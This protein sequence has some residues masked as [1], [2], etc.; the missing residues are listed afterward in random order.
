MLRIICMS[1][2]DIYSALIESWGEKSLSGEKQKDYQG[3]TKT[4]DYVTVE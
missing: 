4:C 2:Y 3:N 1:V